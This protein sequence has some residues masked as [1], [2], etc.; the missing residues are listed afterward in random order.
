ML[1]KGVPNAIFSRF[2][3][4]MAFFVLFERFVIDF[5]RKIDEKSTKKTTH[6]FT[7]ALVFFNMA[8]LT[9]VCILQCESYFF[10]FRVFVFFLK[11]RQKTCYKIETA[12]FSS[13]IT[14]KSSPG[15][16]FGTQ[17]AAELTSE[18]SKNPK[19]VET[20]SF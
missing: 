1:E 14:K 8:T 3:C 12:I 10:I 17:N 9:I 2:L 20:R 18:R 19:M 11:K 7:A 6:F 15:T 5:P 16:H 4:T 13:K